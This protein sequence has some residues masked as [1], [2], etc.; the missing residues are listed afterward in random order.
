MVTRIAKKSLNNS[1]HPKRNFE[2]L[3][4]AAHHQAIEV[5]ASSLN[6]AISLPWLLA[7]FGPQIARLLFPSKELLEDFP[8]NT[9]FWPA[10]MN[11]AFTNLYF[12]ILITKF[13]L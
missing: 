13:L 8:P 7:F 10:F 5:V 3:R 9:I 4:S 11:E 12:A 1:K 2:R 6:L